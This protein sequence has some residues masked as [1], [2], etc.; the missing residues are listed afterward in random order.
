[1]LTTVT[2]NPAVDKTFILP[3]WRIRRFNR[4]EA[5]TTTPGGRG[6]N[7]SYALQALGTEVAAMGFIGGMSGRFIEEELHKS[8]ITTNF[9]YISHETR[10]NYIILN[11]R[12]NLQAQI[13]EKGPQISGDELE[14]FKEFYQRILSHSEMVVIGGSLPQGI[15]SDIYAQLITTAKERGIPAYLNTSGE[16]LL[17]GIEAQPLVIQP[18]IRASD[19]LMGIRINTDRRK[20]EIAQKILDKG[21]EIVIMNMG[22]GRVIV[23]TPDKIWEVNVPPPKAVN[24]VGI[25]DALVGGMAHILH[26]G[27]TIF[28]AAKLGVATSVASALQIEAKVRNREQVEQFLDNIE[29]KELG[30]VES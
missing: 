23:A 30:G 8:R 16:A 19:R 21:I 10:T 6:I 28:E 1:M 29:I 25:G 14:E 24:T 4:A 26:K 12:N 20:I 2:L 27:G 7:A 22:F 15:T 11:N 5:V 17:N 9:V 18:D 3:T 13:N